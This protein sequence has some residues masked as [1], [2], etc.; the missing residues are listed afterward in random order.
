VNAA[1]W[2]IRS[3]K[4]RGVDQVFVLCGNGLNPLLDA[5]P[6]A[7]MKVIDVRNEQAAAYMADLW[8]RMTR[9]LGVVMVSSGPGHTNALTGLTNAWWDRGPMLLISGCSPWATRGKGHFQELDQVGMVKPITKYASIVPAADL[10]PNELNAAIG[11]ALNGRPGPT[12]LTIPVDV[13]S[14]RIDERFVRTRDRKPAI[15]S[16]ASPGDPGLVREAVAMLRQ[17]KRPFILVGSGAFYADAASAL[18]TFVAG[19]GIPVLSHLWDRGCV[20][21]VLPQYMGIASTQ[22]L[23]DEPPLLS[24]ADAVL[25]LGAA[26]DYRLDHGEAT[27]MAKGCRVIR[28]EYDPAALSGPRAADVAIVGDVRSVLEQMTE[29]ARPWKQW[30]HAAWCDRIRGKRERTLGRWRSFGLENRLP[31]PAIRI[32]RELKPFLDKDVT[33]LLDGGNIGRWAHTFLFDRHPAHWLT[34][35]IS[36]VVG[37]GLPG[38]V[39]AKLAR[40]DKPVLLLSGDGAAGFTLAEIETALRFGTPYVAVVAHDAAWGIVVD[41]QP[42]GRRVASELG[43]I[44]FDRVAE[45]LGGRGVYIR[46]PREIGPAVARGLKEDTVTFIHV[47]TELGGIHSPD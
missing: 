26:M 31:V 42:K 24:R 27:A 41:G 34:C 44:R 45:A 28:V 35:G 47:P 46:D 15:V 20:E 19:T 38:A 37:W 10:V 3:L 25:M 43:E 32:C 40:P 18:R 16:Q 29:E 36:G 30:P 4:D 39:A 17:A 2:L 21:A 23:Y 9:R 8:G 6:G 33:F 5:C 22:M 11:A 12:H 13:L 14:G 1:G 7:G